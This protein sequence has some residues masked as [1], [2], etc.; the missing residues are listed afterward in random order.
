MKIIKLTEEQI[1]ILDEAGE[2]CRNAST[3]MKMA[4]NWSSKAQ[5]KFWKFVSEYIPESK[6]K[7]AMFTKD[8]EMLI[9]EWEDDDANL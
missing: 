1:R 7:K 6:G 5:E 4:A 3:A 8:G 9:S 2:E